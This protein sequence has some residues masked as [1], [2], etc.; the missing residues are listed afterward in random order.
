LKV[1]GGE[2][3]NEKV[4]ERKKDMLIFGFQLR[5]KINE[6]IDEPSFIPSSLMSRWRFLFRVGNLYFFSVRKD[7][8]TGVFFFPK[9]H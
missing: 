2:F 3:Q 7:V 4:K 1:E 9:K 8:I 6:L 5:K